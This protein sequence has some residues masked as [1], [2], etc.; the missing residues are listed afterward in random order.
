MPQ[1][2]K[3]NAGIDQDARTNIP[4]VHRLI[5][6]PEF[7][8]LIENYGREA[9]VDTIRDRLLLVRNTRA[10]S[11]AGHEDIKTEAFASECADTLLT[12]FTRRPREVINATGVIIHTN[13]G[14]VPL[15]EA[16][17][18]AA[19]STSGYVDLEYDIRSGKRGTRHDHLQRM[20]H[21]VTGA[22]T[23]IAVNNNA[24]ATLLV[25]AA[26]AGGG[27]EV[28]VSRSEAV[29]IGGGF[30]IPDVLEQ[31]SA[32]LVEVGTT[33]R[34]YASDYSDAITERSAAILKV[35]RSNFTLSGFTHDATVEELADIGRTR[36]VPV[37]HDIG[38][39][40][41]IDTSRYGM[42]HEPMVQDSLR[43]GANVVMFSG[44]K[45]LGGPQAGIIAGDSNVISKVKSHP[46]AR[47]LRVDKT[48]LAGLHV[49]LASYARHSAER[50]I[51]VWRMIAADVAGLKLRAQRWQKMSRAGQVTE[52]RSVIGGGSAPEQTLPT[53]LFE[54]E[55]RLSPQEAAGFLR[56]RDIPI[57]GRVSRDALYLDPRTVLG[58]TEDRA[59]GQAVC[60]LRDA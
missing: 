33:N 15:S 7:Q 1:Q 29:E 60:E 5:S 50:E 6:A 13:L 8:P 53:W 17:R 46:L 4:P 10:L 31:S 37:V 54:V 12:Q 3:S 36:G 52:G 35:H 2:P 20:I 32:T 57:I 47:A 51:P 58:E 34:T 25:L 14:R 18:L 55:S 19:H 59:I 16:A 49:T 9:V 40:A 11:P 48:T 39:G 24:A 42:K 22:E 23:G 41:L 30:R 45:L 56:Q 26:L 44:D 21:R 43:A 27:R 38:S 28:I